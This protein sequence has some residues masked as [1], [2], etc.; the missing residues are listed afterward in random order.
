MYFDE[1]FKIEDDFP[2]TVSAED[3]RLF[4]AKYLENIDFTEDKS[5]WFNKVKAIT[6]Q[7]G[8]ASNM[9]DYKR[10]PD[11]YKGSIVDLTNAFRVAITGR[12]NAPDI[13]EIS[14]VLGKRCVTERIRN[15]LL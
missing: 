12:I 13:W 7:L 6:E 2:A 3:R 14:N 4:F 8:Y 1:S 11:K 10:Q 5:S 15:C 9:K